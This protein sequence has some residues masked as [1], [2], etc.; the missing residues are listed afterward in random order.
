MV[1]RM[2]A[3]VLSILLLSEAVAA[4][5]VVLRDGRQLTGVI[6]NRDQVKRSPGSIKSVWVQ[7]AP[8][9]SAREFPRAEVSLVVLEDS[10][11]HRES[12]DI[13][14]PGNE[15]ATMVPLTPPLLEEKGRPGLG[16]ILAGT[17]VFV[18]GA[19]VKLGEESPETG[20]QPLATEKTYNAVNYLAMTAGVGMVLGGLA[21]ASRPRDRAGM[22]SGAIPG[23]VAPTLAVSIHF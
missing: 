7:A 12:I 3:A 21:I 9:D 1:R 5:V 8:A 23:P 18:L 6:T 10:T 20:L 4:D 13:M 17:A 19:A 2:L 15:R 14:G 22:Q 11:G 16:W